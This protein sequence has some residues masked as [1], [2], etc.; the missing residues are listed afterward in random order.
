ME[1]CHLLHVVLSA[2][3]LF[4]A[5]KGNS[6]LDKPFIGSAV[7]NRLKFYLREIGADDGET[8]HSFRA[9]CSITLAL[10]GVPKEAIAQHVGWSGT[11]MVDCY[12]D[13]SDVFGLNAL[14]AALASSASLVEISKVVQ[15]YESF[16]D[17]TAFT[18]AV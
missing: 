8:P 3:F 16:N 1:L 5:T 4:R 10:L 6:I 7:H 13:L 9:G 17:I 15:A 12:N 11:S 14:A 2:G 18:P